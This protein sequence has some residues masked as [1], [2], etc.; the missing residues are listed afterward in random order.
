LQQL[1]SFYWENH[2]VIKKI[3]VNCAKFTSNSLQSSNFVAISFKP[4]EVQ[5]HF[6][7][8]IVFN[9]LQAPIA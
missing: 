7:L 3:E 4:A 2:I 6:S 1:N 5:H 8:L 9:S